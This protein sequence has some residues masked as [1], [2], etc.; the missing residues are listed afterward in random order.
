MLPLHSALYILPHSF[1]Y[2]TESKKQ[3]PKLLPTTSPNINSIAKQLGSDEL[4]Y[5]TFIT[6]SYGEITFKIGE[7]LAKLQA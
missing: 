4:L 5:Y 1:G 2:Y 3:D 6:Q 7:R